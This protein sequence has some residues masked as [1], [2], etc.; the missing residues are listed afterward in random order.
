MSSLEISEKDYLQVL[1]S[2]VI[3]DHMGTLNPV[4]HM[5]LSEKLVRALKD[6]AAKTAN[7]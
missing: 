4:Q 7:K 3:S 1:F 6:Y 2:Q 5:E